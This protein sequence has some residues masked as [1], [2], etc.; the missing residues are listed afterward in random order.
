[1]NFPPT[2]WQK[3]PSY[4]TCFVCGRDNPSGLKIDFYGRGDEVV[5][6]FSIQDGL[7]GYK[8]IVHGGIVAAILD[9][10]MGWTGWLLLGKCYLT[11][12]LK[13]RYIAP[14]R[15]CE[16]YIFRGKFL[17]KVGKI[18]VA[19]GEIVDSTS[20]VVACGEGKYYIK[21]CEGGE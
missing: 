20:S 4:S 6:K 14:V 15:P 18:Y 13:V 5:A 21:E 19:M 16:E 1:M 2:G 7:C 17:R 9:E 8:G 3:I 12:E 10:G 11:I